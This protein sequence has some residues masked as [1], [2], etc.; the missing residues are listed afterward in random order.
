MISFRALLLWLVLFAV[1]FQGYAAATMAFCAQD[2]PQTVAIE[3]VHIELPQG[4]AHDHVQH[5]HSGA[6]V[7]NTAHDHQDH[8]S[9][10]NDGVHKCGTCG[11]CHSVAL[12]SS[13]DAIP[14]VVLPPADLTEPFNAVAFLAPR[15]LDKPPRA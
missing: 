11:A 12:T 13:F 14:V 9:S 7:D 4:T 15:V 3:L 8:A 10:D 6:S 1:P 5:Q 2:L